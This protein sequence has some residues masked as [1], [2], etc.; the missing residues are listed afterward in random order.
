[1]S[2]IICP[3]LHIKPAHCIPH[4]LFTNLQFFT[5]GTMALLSIRVMVLLV[6]LMPCATAQPAPTLQTNTTDL[7]ALLA[8]KAQVKDPLGILAGN[9]TATAPPCSWVGVSCGGRGQRVTGLEFDSVPLQGSITPASRQ[10][11][12]PLQPCPQQH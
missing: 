5:T 8:F 12:L 9:W 7:A 10:P 4:F 2:L 1:M 6:S 11:L 3:E